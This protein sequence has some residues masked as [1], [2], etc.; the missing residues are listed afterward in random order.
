MTCR[1]IES[2]NHQVKSGERKTS[3]PPMGIACGGFGAAQI[4]VIMPL[5]NYNVRKI[6]AFMSDKWGRSEQSAR[7]DPLSP[8]SEPET[9]CG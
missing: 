3:N 1:S 7:G 5:T 6:A 4:I 2:L 8:Q 9:A